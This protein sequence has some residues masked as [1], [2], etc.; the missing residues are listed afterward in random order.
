MLSPEKKLEEIRRIISGNGCDRCDGIDGDYYK[1]VHSNGQQLIWD[2][3]RKLFVCPRGH[4][5]T[6]EQAYRIES[7]GALRERLKDIA[8]IL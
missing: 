6:F 2:S 8:E 3:R 4:T 1:T 5:E 7:K